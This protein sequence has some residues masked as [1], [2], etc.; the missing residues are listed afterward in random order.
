MAQR[1]LSKGQFSEACKRYGFEPTG[2]MGYYALPK[3]LNNT[4][5]SIWNAGDKR[6]AQLAYL[7]QQWHKEEERQPAIRKATEGE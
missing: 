7:I 5:I 4:H 6:R 2:F 3:P 1:D